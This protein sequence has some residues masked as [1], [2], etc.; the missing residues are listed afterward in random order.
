MH[1][2]IQPHAVGYSSSIHREQPSPHKPAGLANSV[3][4][5]GQPMW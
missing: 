4:R 2:S 5:Y 3:C 1:A